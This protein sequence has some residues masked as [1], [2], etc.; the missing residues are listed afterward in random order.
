M[1]AADLDKKE[2]INR[3]KRSKSCWISFMHWMQNDS[4]MRFKDYEYIRKLLVTV[5][6]Q[7]KDLD[8]I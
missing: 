2:L 6:E 8:D 4:V 5:A 1:E 7:W 3:L